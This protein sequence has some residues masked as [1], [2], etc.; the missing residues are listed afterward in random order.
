[1]TATAAVRKGQTREEVILEMGQPDA[2]MGFGGRVILTYDGGM[3]IELEKDR[4]VRIGRSGKK[5]PVILKSGGDYKGVW[6]REGESETKSGSKPLALVFHNVELGYVRGLR[7]EA[8]LT[9]SGVPMKS[10]YVYAAWYD[11][12]DNPDSKLVGQRLHLFLFEGQP[13]REQFV[14]TLRSGLA[15]VTLILTF[16][17][18]STRLADD[19]T[20]VR[21]VD[22]RG[23]GEPDVVTLPVDTVRDT[24]ERLSAEDRMLAMVMEGQWETS[25]WEIDLTPAIEE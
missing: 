16:G 3:Q 4:V 15:D 13:D 17:G 25:S 8:G 10:D 12:L 2:E 6:G 5:A 21:L 18:Q 11:D 9:V 1:M 23:K 14:Q 7:G 19:I 20:H 24:I 22:A